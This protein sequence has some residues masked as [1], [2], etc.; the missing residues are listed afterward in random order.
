VQVT[1]EELKTNSEKV[2]NT[3]RFFNSDHWKKF[4]FPPYNSWHKA[5]LWISKRKELPIL[6][7]KEVYQTHLS[8][9]EVFKIGGIPF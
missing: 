4:S 2:Q 1:Y 3:E 5:I 9:A 7:N 8:F 6:A